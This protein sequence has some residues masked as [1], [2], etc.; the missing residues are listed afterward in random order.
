LPGRALLGY[1]VALDAVLLQVVA[2][3]QEGL[4][5]RSMDPHRS[6][7]CQRVDI[8][9]VVIDKA[10]GGTRTLAML[11]DLDRRRYE[12]AVAAVVPSV[13][14][15]L[16]PAAVANRASSTAT[17]L[18]LE[19]WT[20][21][22]TRFFRRLARSSGGPFRW[23]FVG[24]V[25]DCYG[26]VSPAVVGLT[27]RR[28]GTREACVDRIVSIL[29][30]FEERGVRGLPVGPQPSAVLA[31]AVLAPVD[32]ALAEAAC[33]PVSR[34][35][36]DVVVFSPGRLG[37]RHARATFHDVLRELGLLAHPEKCRVVDE[38]AAVLG[39]S[40]S[41]PSGPR[42]LPRGMMRPP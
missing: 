8:P 41:P 19:A 27:L 12:A 22:R 13:E 37:A 5:V 18:E 34:W 7:A 11:D 4:R 36:D 2:V 26:S 32:L 33:G 23:A 42:E 17:G 38:P 10:G 16:T 1:N 31:N 39:G 29:R 40:G 24:D 6:S 28:I 9:T 14:R 21:S 3:R 25:R 20:H 35:V 15:S 30:D